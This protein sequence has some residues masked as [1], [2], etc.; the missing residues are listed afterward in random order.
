M[1]GAENARENLRGVRRRPAEKTRMKVAVGAAQG[2]LLADEA[3][4]LG[5]DRRP[6]GPGLGRVAN[7]G[8]VGGAEPVAPGFEERDERRRPRFL[9]AFEKH[10][11]PAGR[12]PVNADPGAKRFEKG[13]HL[14]LVVGGAAAADHLAAGCLLDGRVERRTVPEIERVDGLDVVMAVEQKV[15]R[16]RAD[17]SDDHGVAVGGDHLCGCTHVAEIVREPVRGAANIPRV[18]GIGRDRRDAHE[19]EKPLQSRGLVAAEAVEHLVDGHEQFLL[20]V[21]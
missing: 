17:L 16:A 6:V 20:A 1:Q 8:N 18:G 15:R 3:A 19:V 12:L 10:R 4:K 14:A 21:R 5:A 9:L 2:H 13:H 7:E 11:D